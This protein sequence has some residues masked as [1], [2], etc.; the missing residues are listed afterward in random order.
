MKKISKFRAWLI[1]KLGGI[2]ACE[3]IK[4]VVIEQKIHTE[5]FA[6]TISLTPDQEHWYRHMFGEKAEQKVKKLFIEKLEEQISDYITVH[7]DRDEFGNL[8]CRGYITMAKPIEYE[9]T[10]S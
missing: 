10:L 5:T 6:C 1:R 4:P 2:P 8:N 3:P 7:C 9:N